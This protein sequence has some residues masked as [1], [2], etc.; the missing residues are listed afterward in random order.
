MAG[1]SRWLLFIAFVIAGI[2]FTGLIGSG[3]RYALDSHPGERL[4]SWY[5]WIFALAALLVALL[6]AAAALNIA[7]QAHQ[8]PRLFRASLFALP[9]VALASFGSPPLIAGV[10]ALLLVTWVLKRRDAAPEA[11]GPAAPSTPEA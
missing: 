11:D 8:W 2:P 4:P 7:F 6:F 9:V 3:I 5:G 1:M 10:A